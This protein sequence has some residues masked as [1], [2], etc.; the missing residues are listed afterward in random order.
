MARGRF[1]FK[2]GGTRFRIYLQPKDVE[3]FARPVV[4]RV[5]ARPGTIRPGPSDA[6]MYVVDAL[7]KPPYADEATGEPRWRP[8]YARGLPRRTPARPGRGGHFDRLRPGTRAFSAAHVF[9]T[10]RCVLQI[11]EHYLGRRIR[12]FFADGD[13]RRLEI[14][15]RAETDN[16]WSSEGYLEFGRYRGDRARRFCENFDVIAH[17][18]GHLILKSVIGNPTNA[19]KTLEYRAHEE[20]AADLVA[21][22]S[23][24][25][26]DGVVE[27]LLRDTRGRLFSR[28]VLSRIGEEGRRSQIRKAFNVDTMWS[29][30][31]VRAERKYD[32][33]GVSRP[34]TGGAFDVF[35]GIYERHLVRLHAVPP[36]LAR[37]S[38][39]AVAA[40]L[41]GLPRAEIHQAILG[42]RRDFDAHFARNRATFGKALL[43]ARDDF[44]RLLAATWRRT[45]V[46]R[47]SY[48][49]VVSHMLAADRA[50]SRGRHGPIIRR[51]FRRRGIVPGR[52]RA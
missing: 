21:V 40:A 20:S 13:Y 51:A 24:L 4:V 26:F 42:L 30:S 5:D 43:A 34:F 14:I 38:E 28:N 41:A 45:S 16:S 2:P 52:G 7:G 33:H 27:R 19:K 36:A 31:V 47:F 35:V 10:V 15:P 39:T 3:G 8:P 17:E 37:R 32:K 9:A 46:R 12:W 23:S 49:G 22:V 29:P 50:L 6:R 1:R 25:H 18:T 44:A 48:A 11:W